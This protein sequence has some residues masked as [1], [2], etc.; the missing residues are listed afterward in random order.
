MNLDIKG[1]LK[2]QESSR[3]KPEVSSFDRSDAD[4]LTIRRNEKLE[5]HFHD[6]V[7]DKMY[8]FTTA[9]RWSQYE[10]LNY[11]LLQTGPAD[12][13]LS[14]WKVNMDA[15]VNLYALCKKG[16][17]RELN[18]ILEKRIPVTSPEAV[19]LIKLHA[20]RIKITDNHSKVMVVLNDQWGVSVI[21][22]ANMTTNPR[23]EA[24]VLFTIR[25]IAEWNKQWM[26]E[27]INGELF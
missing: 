18:C 4:T 12:V 20:D 15:A 14:T 8:L 1:I 10:L 22:S 17:I 25:N 5:K 2:Q 16:M 6:L 23:I 11:I 27:V 3:K 26:K 24:G 21:G 9:G 13:Y 19:E 7:K